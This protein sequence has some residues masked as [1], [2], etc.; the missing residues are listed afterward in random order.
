MNHRDLLCDICRTDVEIFLRPACGTPRKQVRAI[1]TLDAV[2]RRLWVLNR[3][4]VIKRI[5]YRGHTDIAAEGVIWMADVLDV[6]ATVGA[7][8]QSQP[9]PRFLTFN[10]S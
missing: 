8:G 4:F 7:C 1:F 3:R 10:A 6:L 2:S 5:A 9:M